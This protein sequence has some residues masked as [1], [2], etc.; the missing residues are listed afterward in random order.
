M[1]LTNFALLTNEQ[2]TVWSMD[3]WRQA[4]NQSFINQFLGKGANSMI[5]HVTELK[6]SEK[7][8]RA[9][10]TLLTDLE[11]DG[12][13][14][15]RT[16]EGNEEAMK[17]FEQVIRVDQLRHANRHEG[18]MADQ[19][20][21]VTFRENSRDALSYWMSDRVDQ[22]A[23]LTLSGVSYSVKNSGG[24][25]LG[26]DLQFLEFAA[27][28][29][30]PTNKRFGRWNGTTKQIEWGVGSSAVT[31]ADTPMWELFV[32]A[33]A[34][35]KDNYIRGVRS[36]GGQEDYKVFI[37][38]QANARLKLDPTYMA[39]L[40]YAAK[41]GDTNELFTG[42]AVRIDNIVIHEFRHVLNTRL[43]PT[44]SKYGAGGAVDGCQLLICG[45]QAMGFADIG[46]AE[47]NEKGFDYENQQGISTGKIIGFLKPKFYTQYSGNTVEDFGVVSIYVA[48]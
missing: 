4:R 22:M 16:L 43:A 10:M 48:Q 40:R 35:M 30:A 45:A 13:A 17:S 7:G 14:G 1:S 31:A 21:V 12:I 29:T 33:K 42:D 11:G 8:T 46:N 18:K 34:Y 37:S 15:D 32:L 38:P 36:D 41:R 20:S 9:V 23:F 26:S 5:Q 19:K 27:D 24:T 44:G 28:V 6:K 2:K 25:R 3:M 39:N 47:W